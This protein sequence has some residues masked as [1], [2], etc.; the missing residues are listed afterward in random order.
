VAEAIVVG[1]AVV[2]VAAVVMAAAVAIRVT[3]ATVE[4]LVLGLRDKDF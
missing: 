2:I 4:T 3:R 1:A